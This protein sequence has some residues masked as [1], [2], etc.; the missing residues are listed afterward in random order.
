[1]QLLAKL[2]NFLYMRFRAIFKF[3][4]N[5]INSIGHFLATRNVAFASV[6]LESVLVRKKKKHYS[7]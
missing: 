4:Q 7:S 6:T 5:L 3:I 1:M 2:E